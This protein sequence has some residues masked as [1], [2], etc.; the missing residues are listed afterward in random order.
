MW[1]DARMLNMTANALFCA[2]LLV[3][4]AS[5][6]IWIAQRPMFAIR[7]I[8]VQGTDRSE[9]RHVTA[10]TVRSTALPRIRGNFFTANLD[11]VR[12]AFEAVPWVRRASVRREWPNRLIV[13]IEEHR[14]LG[15]WGDDGKLVSTKGEVFTVNMAEAEEDGELLSF[16]GPNGSEKEVVRRYDLLRMDFSGLGLMPQA[17]HLSDRYAWSAR[18]SNGM[19][20]EFGREQNSVT[21]KELMVRLVGIYPELAAR[22][23]NRIESIDM[24][25]PNG[26]ALKA[27]GLVLA[28]EGKQKK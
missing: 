23:Q 27:S 21:M 2:V 18:F 28:A 19:T 17:V 3:L 22:L 7:A 20:V 14:P 26:V 16:S 25:Y 12:S 4:L 5:A 13:T 8:Q 6:L 1:Q 9:L 10:S 11:S 24:R 15:T